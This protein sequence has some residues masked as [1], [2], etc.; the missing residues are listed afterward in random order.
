MRPLRLPPKRQQGFTLVELMVAATIGLLLLGGLSALFVNNNNAQLEIDRANRQ[1]ENGRYAMQLLTA[2]LRNAGFY[3]EFD[4]NLMTLPPA[5]PNP[6]DQDITLMRTAIALPVQGYDDG[7]NTPACLT[8]VRANTDIIAVRHTATC[9]VDAADCEPASEGGP[10]FQASSCNNQ[11]EL[12]SSNEANY[13]QVGLLPSALTLRKRDCGVGAGTGSIAPVRRLLTRIYFIANNSQ[14]GDGV[15]TLKR[16]DVV[17]QGAA[18]SVKIVPLAEG[19]ENMQIEYG[20]DTDRD[21]VADLYTT[22]PASANACGDPACAVVNWN[23]VVAV[24]LNLLSRTLTKSM[25]HTDTK[26]YTLGNGADGRPIV[27]AATNDQ[28]KRHV[29]S[30]LVPL[31]NPAGRKPI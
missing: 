10:F 21:G 25:T 29:F 17:Y 11:F 1:V 9:I 23:N 3:G 27:I 30:A 8:D 15:P 12:G 2:D 4:T 13:Y 31:P 14:T 26:S 22:L 19:I 18:W 6:C 5:M 7:A 16:A 20:L 28:Y 24:K